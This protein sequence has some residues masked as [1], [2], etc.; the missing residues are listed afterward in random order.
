MALFG[1]LEPGIGNGSLCGNWK[2]KNSNKR[3]DYVV[4]AFQL[5]NMLTGI[6]VTC[7]WERNPFCNK[8]F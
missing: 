6:V 5:V 3:K 7:G 8:Q 1:M 4:V 2:N